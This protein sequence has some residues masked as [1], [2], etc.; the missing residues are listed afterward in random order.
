MALLLYMTVLPQH[1]LEVQDV[2]GPL[3]SLLPSTRLK[4]QTWPLHMIAMNASFSLHIRRKFLLSIFLRALTQ[5]LQRVEIL[6]GK[7]LGVHESKRD[8]N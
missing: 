6:Q 2:A 1:N 3:L 5:R 7:I 4:K 8:E